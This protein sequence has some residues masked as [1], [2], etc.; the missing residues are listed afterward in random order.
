MK[1]FFIFALVAGMALC[2]ISCSSDDKDDNK[3]ATTEKKGQL[4][5]QAAHYDISTN[6]APK[7]ETSDGQEAQLNAF[8]VTEYGQAVFEVEVEGTKTYCAYDAELTTKSEAQEVY[9][10][11]ERNQQVGT[12]TVNKKRYTGARTRSTEQVE[13][14]FNL[15]IRVEVNGKMT[16]LKFNDT[17]DAQQQIETVVKN[18]T[19]QLTN[20]WQVKRMKL[21]IDFDEEGKKDASTETNDGSLRPFI[22]LAKKN[23]VN[24]SEKDEK[25]LD[26]V[27]ESVIIDKNYLFV[28]KYADGRS[29]AAQWRW[30]SETAGNLAIGIVLK[31]KDMGNKFFNDDSKITVDILKDGSVTLKLSTRLEDDKCNTTLTINLK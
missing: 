31:D 28:L 24:I 13:L 14:I 5:E 22:D 16:D 11:K 26:R 7:T 20:T 27:I 4:D 30:V 21:T 23:G 9:T 12:V 10:L 17:A 2:N 15:T 18:I 25:E 8:N 1:K 29:D 19:T 3:G 6:N